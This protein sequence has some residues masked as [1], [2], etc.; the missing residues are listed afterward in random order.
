[1]KYK[2]R[3]ITI[4]DP[5]GLGRIRV[6]ILSFSNRAN[7]TPWVHPCSPF[8]GP[9]YGFFSLPVVGDSV[10]VE[11]VADGDWV[12]SGF[13]WPK[14]NSLP[15]RASAQI[16][17]FSTP[18]GHTLAFDETG[19]VELHHASGSAIKLLNDGNIEITAVGEI[20]LNGSGARVVTTDCICAFTGS[21]HPQGS[22]TV[23]EKGL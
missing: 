6:R 19:S 5:E 16:R 15:A 11:Q 7:Q 8:A 1:M 2:A 18:A 23:K 22:L 9:G 12:Y 14:K 3:V 17:T 20:H 13:Y 10:W 4:D 21:P